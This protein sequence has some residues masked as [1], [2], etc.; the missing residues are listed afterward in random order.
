[1]DRLAQFCDS[2]CGIFDVL[3]GNYSSLVL[4][5]SFYGSETWAVRKVDSEKIQAFHMTSQ[6]WILVIKWLD[7]VKNTALSEKTCLKDLPLI[8]ADRRHS[9]FG[10]ICRL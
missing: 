7:H 5:V 2:Q 6:W 3:T 8:I 1:M 10:H 4:S 9:L